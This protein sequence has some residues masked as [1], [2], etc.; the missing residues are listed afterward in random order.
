MRRLPAAYQDVLLL[1]FVEHKKISEIAQILD[2]K[3]GTVKSLLSRGLARLRKEMSKK[4]LQPNK[5]ERI[6]K[7]ERND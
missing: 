2:K 5:Q 6:V 7:D 4:P 1:R 3:E